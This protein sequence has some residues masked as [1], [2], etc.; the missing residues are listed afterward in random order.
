MTSDVF[1]F[2]EV[3]ALPAPVVSEAQ[4]AAWASEAFDLVGVTATDLG[5]QQ[6]ANF[7][8]TRQGQAVAVMKVANSAFDEAMIDEQDAAARWI[9]DAGVGL[10]TSTRI[11]SAAR[12]S[13]GEHTCVVRVLAHLDG[14]TLHGSGY[15]SEA[16][17]ADM[18]RVAGLVSRALAT[19]PQTPAERILQWDPRHG[20]RVVE[21]LIEHVDDVDL[22]DRIH[23]ETERAAAIIDRLAPQLPMQPIHGDLTDDNLVRSTEPGGLLDGVI[24]FGDLMVSWRVAELAT[25][26]SSVLHHAETSPLSVLPAIAAFHAQQPLTDAEV[27][28]I[29][30]LVVLRGAVLVTSGYQQIS[31]DADNAYARDGLTREVRIFG[32]AASVPSPVMTAIIR[33]ALGLTSEPA[34]SPALPRIVSGDLAVAELDLGA[35]SPVLDE[36]TWMT[37]ESAERAIDDAVAALF[38]EGADAVIARFGAIDATRGRALQADAPATWRTGLDIRT[39]VDVLLAAPWDGTVVH[40]AGGGIELAADHLTLRLEAAEGVLAVADGAVTA[41]SPLVTLAPGTTWRLTLI[42]AD[43]ADIPAYIVPAYAAGWRAVLRDPAPLLGLDTVQVDAEGEPAG[44]LE[45]RLA[46][47]AEVQEHYYSKPPRI[48]RGWRHH[49]MSADGR[50]YVDMVNNVTVLGHSH[51]RVA[52]AIAR[53]WRVFNSNSRFHYESIVEFSEKLASLLPAPLDTVF[54]VNSGS[55][56]VE[57]SLRLA[58]AHTGRDDLIAVQESYHGWTYLADAVSTS[59]A[60]NPNA[61]ETRPDWLHTVDAPNAFRGKHRGSEAWRYAEEAVAKIRQLVA[62]GRPPAAFICEPVYGAA[63]GVTFPEGYLQAVYGAVREAGGLAIADEVQVGLGRLGD[64]YWG[65]QQQGVIPDIVSMAKSLGDGHPLGAVVT[66]KEIAES[67]ARGGYFFSSTGGSPVSC[68]VGSTVLD[69]IRDERLQ[70]NAA[71]VGRYLKERV[72]ALAAKHPILGEVHGVGLY[73]GVELI[74]DLETL[75]P[76]TEETYE[77]CERMRG[78]GVIVQPTGNEL[79]VLKIKPPLSFDRA[80]ADF[81]VEI[82]DRVLTAGLA[83]GP[84]S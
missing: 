58:R 65:F 73:L 60:D 53:Q 44:L 14:G 34:A 54:L 81:F 84:K 35:T 30:P 38:A 18:G 11:G 71:D 1:D 28:A 24:D 27:E 45:R 78:L 36:G 4:A 61:L 72:A 2:F 68:V 46:V 16:M 75:E 21:H 56:A 80:A 83:S 40:R 47:L 51:P 33:E 67:Y 13:A 31:T 50:A 49:L 15:L 43:I 74:R 17:I 23:A 69:V 3:G 57:L 37:T 39:R 20:R 19:L 64:W 6:D 63:G 8:L 79:N 22:R 48:E 26:I 9:A 82:L 7:L 66:T 5:S 12:L 62:D 32:Q 77:V 52:N 41:G 70:E 59:T 42:A 25:T 29:W 55:E 76:A 10:R